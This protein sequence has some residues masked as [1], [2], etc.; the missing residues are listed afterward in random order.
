MKTL[1]QKFFNN[2][3]LSYLFF[4]VLATLVYL[5]FRTL[6]FYLTQDAVIST[7]TANILAIL[8]AF[9]T[10]ELFVFKQ[11]SPGRWERLVKFFMA[12]LST[13]LLDIGLSYL[14]VTQFPEIIGQFVNHNLQAVNAIVALTS[15]VL[16]IVLNYLISKL[17][18]FT[19]NQG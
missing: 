2:E 18:V 4:G 17:F 15:Q 6:F 16:I 1:I 3:V 13:F 12:R 8:F 7:A 11:K 14:F 10:N 19:N 9:I 5:V